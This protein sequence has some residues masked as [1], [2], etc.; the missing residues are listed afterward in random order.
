MKKSAFFTLG[1]IFTLSLLLHT[2]AFS[3][4]TN[5][6]YDGSQGTNIWKGGTP[7]MESDWHCAKNWS[8]YKVPD[9]FSD[10]I[11][12]DVSST[13]LVMPVIKDGRAEANSLFIYPNASLTIDG[14]AQL[15]VFQPESA[16]F[17]EYIKAK[18]QLFFINEAY[19]K[20]TQASTAAVK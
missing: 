11:I 5:G 1:F 20:S 19:A 2:T 3:Q 6:W 13:T 9:A 10:V 14:P 12:P 15:V 18:G 17:K 16:Y 4:R 8:K 7:G